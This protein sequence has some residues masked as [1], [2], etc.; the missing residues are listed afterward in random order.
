MKIIARGSDTLTVYR[1][2]LVKWD[3]DHDT[4]V[5]TFI[6]GLSSETRHDLAVVHESEGMLFLAWYQ[7]VPACL[8]EGETVEMPNDLWLVES[9]YAIDDT[10][11]FD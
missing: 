11:R 5:L 4:R 2:V 10:I 6:D 3:H 1:G 7:Q 9:S 8:R